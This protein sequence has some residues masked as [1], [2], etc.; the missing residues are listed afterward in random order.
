MQMG[1]DKRIHQRRQSVPVCCDYAD[2][3]D[4]QE[5]EG[6]DMESGNAPSPVVNGITAKVDPQQRAQHD[7]EAE[8]E[9]EEGDE[10]EG[11][12]GDAEGQAAD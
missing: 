4:S 3:D 1:K 12:K 8:S 2:G 6:E 11:E 9:E 5:S 7:S 10:E